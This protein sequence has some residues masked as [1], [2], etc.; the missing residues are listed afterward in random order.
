M[1]ITLNPNLAAEVEHS[2]EV[3]ALIRDKADKGAAF[4][5]GIAPVDTADGDPGVY[6]DAIHVEE[7]GLGA[8]IVADATNQAGVGISVWVEVGDSKTP[9]HHVLAK[10][11]EAL[12]SL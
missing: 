5:K 12:A 2:A 9:P 6:R 7:D 11:G 3:H 4:A 10:T 1:T 8:R